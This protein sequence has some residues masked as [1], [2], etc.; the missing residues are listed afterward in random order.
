MQLFW[1][2]SMKKW[3]GNRSPRLSAADESGSK[4]EESSNLQYS[5]T[6]HAFSKQSQYRRSVDSRSWFWKTSAMMGFDTAAVCFRFAGTVQCNMPGSS[7]KI[8]K[9]SR[10][11]GV[12][13]SLYS[14]I[15][16]LALFQNSRSSEHMIC[17]QFRQPALAW[18]RGNERKDGGT[19]G[20]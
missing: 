16:D 9:F 12:Q 1:K 2:G 13:S 4:A 15:A 8:L 20:L 7:S 14:C 5:L 19:F 10:G 6:A 11:I 3:I 17:S 18:D